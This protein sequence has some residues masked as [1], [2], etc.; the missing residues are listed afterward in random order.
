ML[1]LLG[2]AG[3]L[4]EKAD[5]LGPADL[6]RNDK[7]AVLAALHTTVN[8]PFKAGPAFQPRSPLH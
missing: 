1:G 4:A 5:G 3:P 2:A 8:L 7:R 6:I